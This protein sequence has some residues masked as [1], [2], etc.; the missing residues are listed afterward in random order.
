[1]IN[2][3]KFKLLLGD[4]TKLKYDAIVNAANTSLLGGGGV[5]G[6]IHKASGSK[7]LGECRQLKGCLT[8]NS[9]ITQSY[10][11]I[12][13]GIYWIVHTVGPIFRNN[14]SEK[15]YLRRAY[16][17][18]LQVAADYENIYMNQN[19][20]ILNDNLYRFD[21]PSFIGSNKKE[22]IISDLKTYIDE[23]P[24]KT[25]AFPSISTG[26]YG[27]P[28]DEASKI[29]LDEIMSFI[30][31]HPNRFEE[32]ALI[33]YDNKTLDVFENQYAKYYPNSDVN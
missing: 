7:L 29:A 33:C 12:E 17:S 5:D 18:A 24:I 3:T 23:H 30:N 31:E 14:G 10:N 27:Y 32:I 19:I 4:I 16:N 28:L 8:G 25:I 2:L 11:L 20:K 26:A 6:S 9:K 1:M 21:S 15:K 13:I 22:N